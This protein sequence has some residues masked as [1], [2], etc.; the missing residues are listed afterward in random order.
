MLMPFRRIVLLCSVAAL[1]TTLPLTSALNSSAQ[2]QTTDNR[3]GSWAPPVKA[4]SPK[5]SKDL[6]AFLKEL[7]T[8][9]KDAEKSR[10][11]NPV[12]LQDLKNL[13]ARYEGGGSQ[14]IL[15]DDFSD[16]D[17]DNNPSWSVTSGDYYVE[18]GYG[19]RSRVVEA[20]AA[21]AGDSQKL[22]KEQLAVSLLGAVLGN[23]KNTTPEPANGAA[24]SRPSAIETQ[25]TIPSAFLM[26]V[27]MSSWKADGVFAL[28]V[29]QGLGGAGYRIEYAAGKKPMLQL[30]RIISEKRKVLVSKA[31]GA[32]EDQKIHTVKW[33]RAGNGS[34]NV[35]IDGKDVLHTRDKSFRYPFDSV[36]MSSQG[37]DVIVK[38]VSVNL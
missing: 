5:E 13:T 28:A 34:M 25:V 27:E 17:Y 36:E 30:V 3:Y 4:K 20:A 23:K 8:L 1:A 29:Y 21:A 6:A 18:P 19:L 35:S 11:A 15:F 9:V 22:S 38:S 37:A 14:R 2:A 16:N 10:A 7:D 26:T 31:V 32:L 24:H 12:F 33:M